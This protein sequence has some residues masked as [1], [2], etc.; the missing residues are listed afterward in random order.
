MAVSYEYAL[1]PVSL[2]RIGYESNLISKHLSSINVVSIKI[3]IT[4]KDRSLWKISRSAQNGANL[5]A[6]ERG[7][8]ISNNFKGFRKENSSVQGQHLASFLG[9]V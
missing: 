5:T 2:S 8:T 9:E 6:T 3:N 4:Y 1:G 7:G